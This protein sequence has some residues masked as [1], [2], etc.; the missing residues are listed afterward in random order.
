MLCAAAA[1]P[2]LPVIARA[3]LRGLFV[4]RCLA[5]VSVSG[6]PITRARASA[7][8]RSA[9]LGATEAIADP[10]GRVGRDLVGT[11]TV[12]RLGKATDGR[13]LIIKQTG[14]ASAAS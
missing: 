10:V 8:G 12:A 2:L 1:S 5:E 3:L 11:G 14:L 4:A 6:H 13:V 9:D 7:T